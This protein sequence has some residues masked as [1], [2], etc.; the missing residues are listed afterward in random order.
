M[1]LPL[2]LARRIYSNEG[3]H[4]KVSRPA[5]HISTIGVTIGLAVMIITVSVVLGF[6]IK[7]WALAAISKWRVLLPRKARRPTLFVSTTP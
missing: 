5:I 4:R 6:K 2:F 1:N 7:W 3:D